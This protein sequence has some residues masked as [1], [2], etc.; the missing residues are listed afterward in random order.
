MTATDIPPTVGAPATRA[1]TAAGWTRLDQLTGVTEREL[2]A[3]HGVGPKAIGVLR[4]ALRQRGLR[5]AGE[6]GTA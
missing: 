4:E 1:L 5:L 6:D 3:L 2:R